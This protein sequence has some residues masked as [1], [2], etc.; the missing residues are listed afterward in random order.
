MQTDNTDLIDGD[1]GIDSDSISAQL[2]NP[3]GR[4][5]GVTQKRQPLATTVIPLDIEASWQQQLRQHEWVIDH[6]DE[7]LC[8]SCSHNL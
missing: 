4:K 6:D 1:F 8:L 7:Q 3:E 5:F 2:P